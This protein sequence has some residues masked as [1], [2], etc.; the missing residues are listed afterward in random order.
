MRAS[1]FHQARTSSY[2]SNEHRQYKKYLFL[3]LDAGACHAAQLS[4][5]ATINNDKE[6]P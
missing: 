3:L 2:V 1:P 6:R 5:T 4:T